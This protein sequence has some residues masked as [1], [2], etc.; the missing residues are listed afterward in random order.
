MI[1]LL[2]YYVLVYS[3]NCHIY[4]FF[5]LC[6][7]FPTMT[8]QKLHKWCSFWTHKLQKNCSFW[9]Q[10]LYKWTKIILDPEIVEMVQF[11]DPE[12]AGKM[13]FLDTEIVKMDKR[14]SGSRNR[15]NGAISG[16]GNRR[17]G[18][19]ILYQNFECDTALLIQARK[20]EFGMA[21]NTLVDLLLVRTVNIPN[22]SLL[23]CL[24]A[25]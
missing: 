14:I 7:C 6:A 10:K 18:R 4:V 2:P 8:I 13:Q 21:H 24:E 22:F 11:L 3:F 20:S 1:G 17:K 23:P 9:I 16:S 5:W 25:A 19:Q 12:T 15:R